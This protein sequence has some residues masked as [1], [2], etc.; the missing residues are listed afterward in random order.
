MTNDKQKVDFPDSGEMSE[1]Q[2]GHAGKGRLVELLLQSDPIKER[3]LDDDWNDGEIEDIADYLLANNVLVLPHVLG[4]KV[5]CLAQPCGGCKCYNEPMTKEFIEIC[6][7]CD[8]WEIGVCEF[9]YELIPEW[10]ES[11]FPTKE[12]AEEALRKKLE[13]ARECK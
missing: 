7:K 12:Q 10:G 5:Y 11:V 2:K 6:Q 8:K 4:E 1:G 13:E 9:D 3:D